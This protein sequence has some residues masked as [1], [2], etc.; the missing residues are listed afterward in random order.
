[1][2]SYG[3]QTYHHYNSLGFL[4]K[5]YDKG[6]QNSILVIKAATVRLYVCVSPWLLQRAIEEM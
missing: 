5:F 6:A 4:I 2:K 1:M 3:S